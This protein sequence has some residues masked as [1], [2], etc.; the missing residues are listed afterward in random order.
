MFNNNELDSV[1][2][3]KMA[4]SKFALMRLFIY[5]LFSN[6]VNTQ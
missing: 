2:G 5:V 4:W 1:C 3:K 6:T